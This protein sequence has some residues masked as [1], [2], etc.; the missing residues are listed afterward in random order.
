MNPGSSVVQKQPSLLVPQVSGTAAEV[1]SKYSIEVMY[2]TLSF[3]N[4]TQ[5]GWNISQLNP[6][7]PQP[8]LPNFAQLYHNLIHL[9][10]T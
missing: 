4:I 2:H 8:G 3:P 6:T 7:P 5:F 9:N 10:P 1:L